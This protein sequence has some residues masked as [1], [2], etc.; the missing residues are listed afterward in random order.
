MSDSVQSK[1]N[2]QESYAIMKRMMAMISDPTE[3]IPP[4]EADTRK[5][6]EYLLKFSR[7]EPLLSGVLSS[8]VS[9]DKNRS[10]SLTGGVRLVNQYARKLHSVNNGEGWRQFISQLSASFYS[11]NLG[12]VAEIGENE[13][14]VPQTLWSFDPTRLKLFGGIDKDNYSLYYYPSTFTSKK[15]YIGLHRWEYLHGNSMPSIEENLKNAGFCAVERAIT[16][17]RIVIGVFRYQLEK[18][19]VSPPKGLMLAKGIALDEW[20]QA[21]AMAETEAA[22]S[23]NN[24]Y[25]GILAIFSSNTDADVLLKGFSELPD[26]FELQHFVDIV[27]KAYSLAFNYDVGQFWATTSGAFGRGSEMEVQQKL[28]TAK[29]ELEFALS[30]QEQIKSWFLPASLHFEFDQRNDEG[31]MQK[32]ETQKTQIETLVALY[33]AGRGEMKG[34]EP[35]IDDKNKILKLLVQSGFAPADWTQEVEDSITQDIKELREVVR[36][37]MNAVISAKQNPNEPIIRYVWNG[38]NSYI[39]NLGLIQR[40]LDD[41]FVNNMS[42]YIF[43]EGNVIVLYESGEDMLRKKYY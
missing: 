2:E 25:K 34:G 31:D 10:W 1:Y 27:M 16:I 37:D 14:F 7:S 4:Y 17:A 8:V 24:F 9:R 15:S 22:N 30:L 19:G 23:G 42:N 12:Y 3:S 18:L 36:S 20:E 26:N 11:T 39:G 33:E 6:D 21:R 41:N 35:L 32:A 13:L 29:G 40:G 43:P 38:D 28:A 5:R